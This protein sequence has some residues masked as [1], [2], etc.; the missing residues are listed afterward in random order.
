MIRTS[1]CS[2]IWNR[3]NNSLFKRFIFSI[4]TKWDLCITCKY[5]S[6]MYLSLLTADHITKMF[7]CY[8]VLWTTFWKQLLHDF[9][10]KSMTNV[11]ISFTKLSI[12]ISSATLYGVY[13][14]QLIRYPK[15]CSHYTDLIYN[16][17]PNVDIMRK[18]D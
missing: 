10:L 14:P 8:A 12:Y 2:Y 9:A 16:C 13:I 18:K 5:V 17:A 15:A 3:V 6:D 4:N 11:M 1:F 7:S